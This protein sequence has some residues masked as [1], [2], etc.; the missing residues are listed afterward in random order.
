M[1]QWRMAPFSQQSGKLA[2]KENTHGSEAL[3]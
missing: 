2:N 3:I 1:T